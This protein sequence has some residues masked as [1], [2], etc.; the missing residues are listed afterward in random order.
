MSYIQKVLM[1]DE[2]V[3]YTTRLS[4][5]LYTPVLW[6]LLAGS[7][8]IHYG[9]RI[10]F[11]QLKAQGYAIYWLLGLG[12][13]L[14]GV[15]MAINAYILLRTSEYALTNYRVIA[16]S[17]WLRQVSFDILLQKVESVKVQQTIFGRLF[18]Y[19]TVIIC[20]TGGSKDPFFK[21]RHP[22]QFRNFIQHQAEEVL[23]EGDTVSS[24]TG[25]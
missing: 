3:V 20:G 19:G 12:G 6:W 1:S 24:K 4:H 2:R 17:G 16:K 23:H 21:I 15:F 5:V 22:L 14:F 9:N 13:L 18:N 7:A 25:E 11:L 8:L 10:P